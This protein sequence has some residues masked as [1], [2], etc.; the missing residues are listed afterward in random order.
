MPALLILKAASYV[1]LDDVEMIYYVAAMIDH[2]WDIDEQI[3][4]TSTSTKL[5]LGL[6]GSLSQQKFTSAVDH[7]LDTNA[8]EIR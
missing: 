4:T 1:K 3:A 5:K 6:F 8:A 2:V 7:Q